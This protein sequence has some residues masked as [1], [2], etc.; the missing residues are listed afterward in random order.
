M[1]SGDMHLIAVT[2][3]IF[4]LSAWLL[5]RLLRKKTSSTVVVEKRVVLLDTQQREFKKRLVDALHGDF[6][7]VPRV[8]LADLISLRFKAED[9]N[10]AMLQQKIASIS[11]DFVLLDA[12]SGR[13]VCV[14]QLDKE[15]DIEQTSLLTTTCQKA[16]LTLLHFSKD[17]ALDSTQLKKKVLSAVEPTIQVDDKSESELVKVYL[18]PLTTKTDDESKIILDNS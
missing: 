4:L 13:I 2:G 5:I 3:V 11:V 7:V 9:K 8:N 18:E 15:K 12:L 16:K 6:D 10:S 1:N 17:T 14:V